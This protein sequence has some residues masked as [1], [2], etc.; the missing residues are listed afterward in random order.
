MLICGGCSCRLASIRKPPFYKRLSQD[1]PLKIK[2]GGAVNQ[3]K[4]TDVGGVPVSVTRRGGE[5]DGHEAN[6]RHRATRRAAPARMEAVRGP[7]DRRSRA[8][9]RRNLLPRAAPLS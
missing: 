2:A 4:Y 9:R 8:G 7:P 1:S 5:R 6:V 3:S